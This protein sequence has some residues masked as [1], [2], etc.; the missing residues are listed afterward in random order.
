MLIRVS[1]YND[2]AKEYLEEGVKKERE[3]LPATSWMNVSCFGE[4][5]I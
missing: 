3:S 5:L 2:G 1:G 4:I